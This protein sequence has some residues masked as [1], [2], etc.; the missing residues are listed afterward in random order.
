MFAAHK[1][2]FIFGKMPFSSK[3]V[4]ITLNILSKGVLI[5]QMLTFASVQTEKLL[6]VS[7]YSRCFYKSLQSATEVMSPFVLIVCRLYIANVE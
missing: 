6:F 5:Q 3:I 1:L 7:I 2:F 4:Q